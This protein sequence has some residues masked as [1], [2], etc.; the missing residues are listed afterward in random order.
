MKRKS[1]PPRS[2]SQ[3]SYSE[4]PNE[5]AHSSQVF[6]TAKRTSHPCSQHDHTLI[7][8]HVQVLVSYISK[9]NTMKRPLRQKKRR[10]SVVV[11]GVILCILLPSNNV[12]KSRLSLVPATTTVNKAAA[13][14][15]S[16]K[17]VVCTR[18]K[19]V[20][21]LSVGV[22]STCLATCVSHLL[23]LYLQQRSAIS[24]RMD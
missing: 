14:H 9:Q 21:F 4:S 11:A 12:L 20:Q 6:R 8:C 18:V 2:L 24:Q 13:R 17:L 22:V 23:T 19:S 1:W 3:F 10:P 16:E 7:I 5:P 15:Q